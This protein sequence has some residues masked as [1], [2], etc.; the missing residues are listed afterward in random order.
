MSNARFHFGEKLSLLMQIFTSD[1]GHSHIL[2]VCLFLQVGELSKELQELPMRGLLAAAFITYLPSAPEDLR[3]ERI[4]SWMET[5]GI[6]Q[7]DLR[8]FLSTESEQLKWKAE[9][10]PS[11]ELSMEN[12]LVILQVCGRFV[13][14][15]F[16]VG[17]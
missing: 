3:R 4:K 10:L 15:V 17:T 14:G 13:V 6:K 8:R 12:A 1:A 5:I 11:D 2:F 9:G 16:G 7:F